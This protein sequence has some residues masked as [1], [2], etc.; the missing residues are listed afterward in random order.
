MLSKYRYSNERAA[1][2]LRKSFIRNCTQAT[3]PLCDRF[4]RRFTST[5]L[6]FPNLQLNYSVTRRESWMT[7]VTR[8]CLFSLTVRSQFSLH[9]RALSLSSSSNS[10][11]KYRNLRGFKS[12]SCIK[13]G[14][15]LKD[16]RVAIKIDL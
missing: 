14:K 9:I 16:N 8:S 5:C 13:T 1:K 3:G 4:S 6:E 11:Y 2:L 10:S 12:R 15:L 7:Q